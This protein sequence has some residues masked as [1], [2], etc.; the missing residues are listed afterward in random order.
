MSGHRAR[1]RFGQNF[2]SD[3]G[4]IQRILASFR[5]ADADCV[6]E[7]GPGQGALTGPL[8]RQLPRLH[9]VELDRDLIPGL[10]HM[11]GDRQL[12]V[13]QADALKFDFGTLADQCGQPIRVIGN[14]PYNISTPLLF[15]LFGFKRSISDMLFMLQKEVV[16]RL[17]APPGS[18]D[19]GR[20]SVMAQYHC[21]IEPLFVVRPGAFKPQPKV[22][23]RIVRLKPHAT[24]PVALS[25]YGVFEMVVR[26]C[27]NQR[28]KTLR[29]NLKG[30]LT[31][32]QIAQQDVDPGARAETLD[33]DQFARLSN[34]VAG[35]PN[36]A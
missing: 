13:H 29:N 17:A 19:Y 34:A 18:G 28:R 20:L 8:L 2:L 3:P 11:A 5:P 16:D 22:D 6:V 26:S 32:E 23:S 24:P 7:I 21:E 25:D 1:K 10:Q 14:L 33:M 4:V 36:Q 30:M 9:V 12:A 35:L 15:H 31:A 27:F